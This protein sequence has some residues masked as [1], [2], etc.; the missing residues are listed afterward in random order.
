MRIESS[1][2]NI[3]TLIKTWGKNVRELI[4]LFKRGNNIYLNRFSQSDK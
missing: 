2:L 3:Q 4:K 1:E